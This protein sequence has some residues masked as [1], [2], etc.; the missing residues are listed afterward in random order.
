MIGIILLGLLLGIQHTMEADHLT[1]LVS[2][3]AGK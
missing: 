3:M 1:A 2:I